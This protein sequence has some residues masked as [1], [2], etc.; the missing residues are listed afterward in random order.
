MLT[1]DHIFCILQILNKNGK[2]TKQFI[3]YLWT[4]RKLMIQFRREVLYNILIESGV[5][6][7]LV[8]LI[9]MCL[10][11]TYNR[12]RVG[13]NLSGMFPIENGMKQGDAL[14]PLL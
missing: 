9:K 11:E 1:A 13:K 12:F 10:A 2:K 3:S 14:K 8:R 7:E 5:Q 4:S 6:M